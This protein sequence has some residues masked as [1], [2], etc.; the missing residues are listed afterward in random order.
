[1]SR[2]PS[3]GTSLSRIEGAAKVTG[4]AKFSAEYQPDGLLYGVVVS[5]GIARGR[6]RSLHTAQAEDL[7]G[8]VSVLSHRC[9]PDVPWYKAVSSNSTASVSSPP[10]PVLRD[11]VIFYSGQPIALVV[12]ETF[13][14]ARAGAMLVHADYEA[15]PH[16]TDF[17]TALAQRFT[18]KEKLAHNLR[19]GNL[20]AALADAAARIDGHYELA[21]EH[22]NPIEMHA[23]TVHRQGD[24]KFVVYDKNQGSQNA[25]R[26]LVDAFGLQPST[27]KVVNHHVGGAFG[28]G[29]RPGYQA[30]LAMLAALQLKRSIRVAMTRQQMFTHV[31]RPSAVQQM[32]LACDTRGCLT[33]MSVR[34][35]TSTA[36]IETY[37]ENLVKWG[38][39]AYACNNL[40]LDYG[41]APLDT[42]TPGNMRAP[43][44]ATGVTLLEMALDELAY[45]NGM[46][47]LVVRTMNQSEKDGLSGHPYTSKALKRAYDIGASRF[48]WYKRRHEPRSMRD[49]KELVGLGMASGIWE[50]L[51]LH[52]SATAV[53]NADGTVS[54]RSAATDLGT[55]TYTI[56]AQI[57]AGAMALP[58]NR[59]RVEIGESDLPDSPFA[60]GSAMAASV[61]AAVHRASRALSQQW[62]S[63]TDHPINDASPDELAKHIPAGGLKASA[64]VE[65]IEND[66]KA[67]NTHAA[68]FAEVRVDEQL[69]VIRV[70]RMLGVVAAGR[71]IN[72]KTAR[73]QVLGGLVMGMGM[74]L[75]EETLFDHRLGR[76]MNHNLAEYHIPCHADV[77]DMEAIFVEEPDGQISP[78]GVKGV[79]EIGI[80]GAAAAIANAVFHATGKRLRK[81]PITLDKLL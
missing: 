18:P 16:N 52:A 1:M 39:I 29:L 56:L 27:V 62:F 74:A 44:A 28:S 24:G 70:T 57:A 66:G 55:G 40:N 65:P 34:A 69:G 67:R 61:G 37:S 17:E 72:P 48:G 81:L 42:P 26:Q 15:E 73:S 45:A 51:V 20:D 50:A 63:L 25:Q 58:I 21:M 36:R 2:T 64:S 11:D 3:I 47:P 53:L 12:A 8:V 33:A 23:T 43:G 49:G 68:I 30:Y 59:I 78:L 13:E 77:H 10:Y 76:I 80:V 71:I 22:H 38:A 9:R 54:I 4:S 7:P 32:Q 75:H 31:H 41:V 19:R 5:A 60:G 46:D 14:A 79:G 35:T 6:I